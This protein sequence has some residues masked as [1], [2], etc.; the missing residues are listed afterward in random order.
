[1]KRNEIRLKDIAAQ[2]GVSPSAVSIV[3]KNKK[4]V[5]DET[6]ERIRL[7][8]ERYG[9][10]VTAP[11]QPGSSRNIR[12]LKYKNSA[13]LVEENAPKNVGYFKIY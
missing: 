12:F 11:E 5:S 7:T 1:M 3:M 8:L 6:R 10:S 9:Y 2:L 13:I 4:G